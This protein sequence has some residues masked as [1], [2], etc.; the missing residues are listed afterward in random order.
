MQ[1]QAMYL[2]DSS[3]GRRYM[4]S[5]W[6]T[7]LQSVE[8]VDRPR[9]ISKP[10]QPFINAC[11]PGTS[12][13]LCSGS[14]VDRGLDLGVQQPFHETLGTVLASAD[15][16]RRVARNKFEY[17]GPFARSEEVDDT[18]DLPFNDERRGQPP[19][20]TTPRRTLTRDRPTPF[21]TRRSELPILCTNA[22]PDDE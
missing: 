20:I 12:T 3:L 11:Q 22:R 17:V 7:G 5:Y 16:F 2:R 8:T 1:T 18:D 13:S 21:A 15:D 14:L 4:G 10:P 9:L 6:L 19:S